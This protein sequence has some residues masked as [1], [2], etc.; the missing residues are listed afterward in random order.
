[1][2]ALASLPVSMA[3]RNTHSYFNDRYSRPMKTL[4]IQRPRPSIEMWMPASLK[5]LMKAKL[6]NCKP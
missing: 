5:V 6:V 3:F 1:M 2:P 4:S